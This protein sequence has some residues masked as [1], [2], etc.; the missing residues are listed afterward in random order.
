MM[1]EKLKKTLSVILAF[2]Y[3]IFKFLAYKLHEMNLKKEEEIRQQQE[4]LS[5][6]IAV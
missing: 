6:I 4:V 5:K 1:R 3:G 2:I